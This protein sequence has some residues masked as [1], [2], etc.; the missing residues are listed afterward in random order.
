M[1]RQSS[2]GMM[3]PGVKNL[4]LANIAVF[5]V[6]ILAPS[7][8]E[9]KYFILVPQ[10]VF[11]KL[12]LWQLVTYMFLHG[13][14]GH[15]FFNMFALWMF[16]IELERTWGTKEFLKYYF[17]TGIGAGI[18]IALFSSYPTIGASGAVYGVL[19]AFALFFPDR[20]VYLYFLFPIKMKYLA[21]GLGLLEFLSSYRA[22]DGIAH[23]AHLGGMI[24][25]FFYLRYKYRHWGIGQNFFK[26]LFRRWG[27]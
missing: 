25:G 1:Y 19:A 23:V 17:L 18:F 10:L 21:L 9:N 14:L 7:L 3:T 24:I 6:Q 22:A 4:L 2:S 5:I 20:Y 26:N 11:K 12:Y 15:I 13:G 16:G 27:P 8:V